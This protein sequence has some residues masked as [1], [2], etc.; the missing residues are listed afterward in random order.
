MKDSKVIAAINKDPDAPILQV[1]DVGLVGDLFKKVPELTEKFNI[2][3]IL[4]FHFRRPMHLVGRS[5]ALN[6]APAG[7][8]G[9][10]LSYLPCDPILSLDTPVLE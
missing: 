10:F 8:S 6:N 2:N 1:A 4:P 5:K 7:N 3:L 9:Y